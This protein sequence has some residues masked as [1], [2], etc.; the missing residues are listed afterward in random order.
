VDRTHEGALVALDDDKPLPRQTVERLARR[1]A[2]HAE[3]IHHQSIVNP[4]ARRKREVENAI[5]DDTHGGFGVGGLAQ[6]IAWRIGKQAEVRKKR[7]AGSQAG[8]VCRFARSRAGY[9]AFRVL[10]SSHR[11]SLLS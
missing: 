11:V 6:R 4:A 8:A 10:P 5:A 1:R 2:T 7:R 3:A 9:R